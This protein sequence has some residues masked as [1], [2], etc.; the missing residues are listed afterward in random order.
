MRQHLAERRELP[1]VHVGRAVG[2]IAK[3][4]HLEGAFLL[5]STG[6]QKLQL[7]APIERRVAAPA[8]AVELVLDDRARSRRPSCCAANSTRCRRRSRFTRRTTRSP[9]HPIIRSSDRPIIRS[10]DRRWR[11]HAIAR[12]FADRPIADQ[13]IADGRWPIPIADHRSPIAD[14]H[15]LPIKMPDAN[16]SDPPTTTWT[17]ARQNGVS[18]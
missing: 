13:A 1:G 2:D 15:A 16:T 11:D 4:R 10:S 12:S 5:V 7:G 9:D 17:A 6:R 3:R 18:M 8:A 14:G